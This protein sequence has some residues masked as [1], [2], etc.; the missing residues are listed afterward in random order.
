MNQ[1]NATQPLQL[2]F[3]EARNHGLRTMR[4]NLRTCRNRGQSRARLSHSGSHQLFDIGITE[5]E[6]KLE[7]KKYFWQA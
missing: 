4:L 2:D 3:T 5:A 1:T 7:V 6:R